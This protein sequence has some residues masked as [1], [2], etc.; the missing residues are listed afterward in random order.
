MLFLVYPNDSLRFDLIIPGEQFFCLKAKSQSERQ[1]WIVALGT[2]KSR[3]MTST[4]SVSLSE[5]KTVPLGKRCCSSLLSWRIDLTVVRLVSHLSAIDHELKLK[6]QEL[7]LYE[8]VLM[9]RVHALKSIVNDKATPDVS[10]TSTLS[11][12]KD[13]FFCSI[14]TR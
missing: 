8:S 4:Q 9:Q 6:V 14:E 10:V 2:S 12:S 7:R 3:G 1:R 13:S 11:R 5:E